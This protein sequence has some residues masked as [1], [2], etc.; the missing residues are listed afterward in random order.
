LVIGHWSLIRLPAR[1]TPPIEA[2]IYRTLVRPALRRTFHRV[3]LHG[4]ESRPRPELPTLVYGSHPSWWDGYMA[5]LMSREVWRCESYLMMEEPQLRRYGFFRYCGA[6]SVDRH[7]PREGM[8]AV[9]Y[10]A[11]LLRGSRRVVWIFPQG[12]IV[13]NDRRPLVTFSG[14]AHVAKRA[15]PVCCVPMALRFE[16]G[17]EQRPE[18]LI[19][20]GEPHVVAAA[21]D[22]RALHH[23]MDQRLL[24][25][26]DALRDDVLSGATAGYRTILKGRESVNVVW[27]RVRGRLM[28]PRSRP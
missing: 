15:A 13:P 3:A 20:L 1:K 16:F 11:D 7:D 4:Y 9:R 5:F 6:F 19:R 14:A 2:M 21:A 24:N 8:R 22:A 10:A 26:M 27:D 17:G 23:E 18:A 25:E 12:E 28:P